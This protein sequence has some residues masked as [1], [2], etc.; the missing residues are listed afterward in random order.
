MSKVVKV[1]VVDDDLS[2]LSG[3]AKLLER[4]NFICITATDGETGIRELTE[5]KPDVA[6]VD[7]D[8]PIM[9]GIEFARHIREHEL[10]V[11]VIIISGHSPLELPAEIHTVGVHAFIQKPIN[12]S[13]LLLA[14][15]N[16]LPISR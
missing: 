16:V 2:F 15:Q 10:G 5:K 4:E 1:L 11:P 8:M 6:L 12:I 13:D 9:N 3:I 7:L 14:I